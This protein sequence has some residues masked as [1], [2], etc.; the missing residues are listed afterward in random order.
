[1][2]RIGIVS[3]RRAKRLPTTVAR[4]SLFTR[5]GCIF[6]EAAD[7]HPTCW[8]KQFDGKAFGSLTHGGC[9]R[10]QVVA[11]DLWWSR[12]RQ[13]TQ[14]RFVDVARVPVTKDCRQRAASISETTSRRRISRRLQR[15]SNTMHQLGG[16]AC[17][18][19]VFC[20]DGSDRFHSVANY[21]IVLRQ[22]RAA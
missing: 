12:H 4:G 14:G 21:A 2:S 18:F 11:P 7:T 3:Q 9:W 16:R 5:Q 17:G 8:S 10:K 6:Q 19:C 15:K 13:R 20:E 1:M 22:I